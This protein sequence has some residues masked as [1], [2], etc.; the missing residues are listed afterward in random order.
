MAKIIEPSWPYRG[1]GDNHE[2]ADVV[3]FPAWRCDTGGG[4]AAQVWPMR[5][6]R[7][8]ITDGGQCWCAP[9]T[10]DGVVIHNAMDG[11]ERYERG[12]RQAN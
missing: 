4:L 1:G 5:D 3:D 8:H 10:E 6:L 11:R 7:Q 2:D 12:E 9:V